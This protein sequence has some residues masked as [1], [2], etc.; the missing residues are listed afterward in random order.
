MRLLSNRFIS[1]AL[2]PS[3][4]LNTETTL[5]NSSNVEVWISAA[6]SHL[7]FVVC[8]LDISPILSQKKNKVLSIFSVDENHKVGNLFSNLPKIVSSVIK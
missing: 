3:I 4:F 1:V 2:I 5:S 8:N 7:P 6:R